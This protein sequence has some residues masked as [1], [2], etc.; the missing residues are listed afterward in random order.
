METEIKRFLKYLEIELS[1]SPH[2]LRAYRSD[3]QGFHA[4]LLRSG[5][6]D[7]DINI[8]SV[9]RYTVR[10]YLGYLHVKKLSRATVERKLATIKTFFR[11]L[12]KSDIISHDPV[13]ILQ[14]PRKEQKLPAYLTQSE[15]D[16][17]LRTKSSQSDFINSRDF[18][19]AELLYGTGIRVSELASLDLKDVDPVSEMILIHGKGGKERVVPTTEMILEVLNKYLE[20]RRMK[21]PGTCR[22]G[23][24]G[25]LFVNC[26]GSRL[27]VRSVRRALKRLGINQNVLKHVHPHQLR[28]SFATHMLESG[29]DLRAIQEILGHSSLGTTQKYT[30]LNLERLLRIYHDKHPKA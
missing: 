2:T 21:F 25:P 27:T 17:L 28:H 3:L 4:F 30:H 14:F 20:A 5:K 15:V 8:T 22:L 10:S 9:D 6:G 18:A 26:R 19:M 12:K 11:F 24:P 23:T 1:A 7:D 16:K 29:A 13:S